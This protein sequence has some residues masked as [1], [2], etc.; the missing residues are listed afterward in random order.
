MASIRLDLTQRI[1]VC[2]QF[3]DVRESQVITCLL[4]AY[5]MLYV[6]QMCGQ[7]NDISHG[8]NEGSLVC[9]MNA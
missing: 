1:C 9:P 7:K 4:H 2:T 6:L 8:K 5:E 3:L